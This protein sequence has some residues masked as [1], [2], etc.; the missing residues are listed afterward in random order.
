MLKNV[1]AYF[2]NLVVFT[3][4]VH[5][6]FNI[7]HE[8][9]NWFPENDSNQIWTTMFRSKK[10]FSYLFHHFSVTIALYELTPTHKK[11]AFIFLK[12]I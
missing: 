1:Q 2:K 10:R 8:K 6:F 11:H 9:V 7:I 12:M 3:P 5:P 4:Y